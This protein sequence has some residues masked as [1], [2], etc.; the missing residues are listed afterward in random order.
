MLAWVWVLAPF[1]FHFRLLPAR[2][3]E[4]AKVAPPKADKDDKCAANARTIG[5]D[6]CYID[7]Q[8]WINGHYLQKLFAIEKVIAMSELIYFLPCLALLLLIRPSK[9]ELCSI[10]RD[11]D[12]R[13]K[14]Q[15]RISG[16]DGDE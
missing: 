11:L 9:T 13:Y 1:S 5:G 14:D 3:P 12:H 4:K 7:N 16:R 10:Q 8:C 2:R 6:G 15:A